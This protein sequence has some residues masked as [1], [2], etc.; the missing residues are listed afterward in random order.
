[1][2]IAT[3]AL[4][5]DEVGVEVDRVLLSTEATDLA[6]VD[7]CMDAV[8]VPKM[9]LLLG[10]N[11]GRV[12]GLAPARSMEAA[13][14]I[15]L[16]LILDDTELNGSWS[17]AAPE[18]RESPLLEDAVR[19]AMSI[20]DRMLGLKSS[21]NVDGVEIGPRIE[22]LMECFATTGPWRANP[23][24]APQPWGLSPRLSALMMSDACRNLRRYTS[25]ERSLPTFSAT[26]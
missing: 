18:A 2:A 23:E 7:G 8:L 11:A 17:A 24:L 22:L 21:R 16:G 25:Q 13:L 9:I 20:A 5:M 19:D 10:A 6:I 26:A 15:A 3:I 4:L 1:M 14:C 12:K